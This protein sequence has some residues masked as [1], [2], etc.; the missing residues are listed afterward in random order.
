MITNQIYA[1]GAMTGLTWEQ[2]F[3]W[4]DEFAASI[5][6]AT[7]KWHVFNPCLHSSDIKEFEMNERES[8]EYDLFHLLR[9]DIVI[10]NFKYNAGSVGTLME[11]GAA[12]TH[13]IPIIGLNEDDEKLHPWQQEMCLKIFTDY[14]KMFN[15]IVNHFINEK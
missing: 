3:E 5:H 9:S 2:Q 12:Y 15:Y 13:N 10:V 8:M 4:R 7:N 11:M 14:N 6:N 1:A